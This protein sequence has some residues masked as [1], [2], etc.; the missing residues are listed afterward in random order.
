MQRIL[1]KMHTQTN[2]LKKSLPSI[3]G[4]LIMT[5]LIP[6]TSVQAEEAAYLE[7]IKF[8][9]LPG[10]RVQINLS[11]SG[12]VA[13][14]TVFTVDEPARIAL[15]FINTKSRLPW[16][17]RR[18]GMGIIKSVAAI[19]AGARTRIVV[20]LVKQSPYNLERN[21]N[22]LQLTLGSAVVAST[23]TD[24]IKSISKLPTSAN[25]PAAATKTR[26][27]E[28]VDFRRG[29]SG[30]GRVVV[31]FSDPNVVVDVHEESGKI[32]VDFLNVKL[33]E[34]MRQR[35][36]VVDFATPV[37]TVDTFPD[38]NN[39]RL[40]ITPAGEYEHLAY[41]SE[42]TL[43]VDVKPI[44]K[45]A[46]AARRKTEYSGEKLS[47]NFQDIEVRAVLQLLA[48]F[49]GLNVVVSDSVQGNITLRLKNVPWDQALDIILKT[50]G[51][52]MRQNG[53]VL[54][55]APGEEIA[56]RE[57]L[58]LEAQKQISELA[59]LRSELIQVNYAKA[60]ELASL[61]KSPENSLLSERGSVS[62]DERTNTL[63]VRDSID[64][65]DEVRK[66]VTNLDIPIRQVL[67]E[68]RIVIADDD[69]ARDLGTRIGMR[70]TK[71]GVSGG[72][73]LIGGTANSLVA[74]P[75]DIMT[76]S[77][78]TAI[79][80]RPGYDNQFGINLP[81]IASK[82]NPASLALGF[83]KDNTLLNL[84]LSALQTELRGE[85][86][87]S[88]RVITSNQRKAMIEQGTEIPYKEAS[89][90]GAA[91]TSFRKAVMS[92]EVTPQITPDDRI[93]LDIKVN[94]DSVSEKVQGAEGAPAIDTNE[95]QTQ[96]L[97]DNGETVV[98]GGI[99]EQ[100]KQVSKAKV[101]LLGDIPLIG[102]LF[103]SKKEIND[104]RELL[105]FVTPK[106]LKEQFKLQ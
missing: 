89:S 40:V 6:L 50:K 88:P 95:V 101:P 38:G 79:T 106:I 87:S 15:D 56:G 39:V 10:D 76:S 4:L 100:V 9:S 81:A 65:L 18:V 104:K 55:V 96:V 90:S 8:T 97:V 58:E 54:L 92:L 84:E 68:S 71:S 105:I 29:D 30:E 2:R 34:A 78:T 46:E 77:S 42:N 27:V 102:W 59:P 21:G 13:E 28:S 69:F 49:S 26:G 82:G 74:S 45:A 47:L 31:T 37:Q 33:P 67:I 16:R 19:E 32:L 63:L 66:L 20:N 64:R 93:I 83:L 44:T 99:Y 36:D 48:D 3:A 85:I 25:V 7:D 70:G 23:T 62:V 5:W 94:K 57:K 41:Q 22:E 86:V 11:L 14:P 52:A 35:L 51:L 24:A 1:N 98:L 60:L 103:R 61:L 80:P 17:S 43:T 91:T 12:Q 72:D 53:N 75:R 73:V